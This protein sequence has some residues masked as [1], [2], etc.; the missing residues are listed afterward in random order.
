MTNDVSQDWPVGTVERRAVLAATVHDRG[1][2]LLEGLRRLATPLREVFAGFGVLATT[3]TAPAVVSFL[4]VDLGANVVRDRPSDEHVGAHRREAV[5]LALEFKPSIVLYSDLD[6][7]MRWIEADRAELEQHLEVLP[8]DFLVIGR[9]E[10]ARSA[11]P[12]RLRL[13]EAIVN[14]IYELTTGRAWDLMFAFRAMSPAAA[15]AI[16]EH[17]TENSI[18]SDIEWPMLAEQRGLSIA[19]REA[20]GLSYRIVEDFD[21]EADRHDTDPIAWVTRVEIANRHAQ[22]LKP[23]CVPRSTATTQ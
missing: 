21:D 18:A 19:Y 17:G 8:A 6:H 2:N 15:L 23:V 20:N 13:T 5:R 3:R 11:C 4:E 22:A 12:R 7:V 1:G 14:H 9:T 16:V 10:D